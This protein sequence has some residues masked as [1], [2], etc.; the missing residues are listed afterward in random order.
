MENKKEKEGELDLGR[1]AELWK[2]VKDERWEDVKRQLDKQP[3]AITAPIT[4]FYETILHIL[5]NWKDALWLVKEIIKDIEEEGGPSVVE[6]TDYRG[7]TPLS[8]AASVGNAE[9]AEMIAQK[10]PDLLKKFNF[11]KESPF[12]LAAKARHEETFKRMLN[13]GQAKLKE[14]DIDRLFSGFIGASI[15][16]NLLAANLYGLTVSLLNS[17]PKLGRDDFKHRGNILKIL[18]EKPLAFESGCN[19]GLWERFIYKVV[20]VPSGVRYVY[21]TKIK[22]DQAR[23]VVHLVCSGVIWTFEDA[24]IALKQPVLRAATLGI[25]EIVEEILTVYPAATMFHNPKNYNI[26]QLAVLNRRHKVFNLYLKR[27]LSQKWVPTFP[28]LDRENNILHL[29]GR[30]V[31]S[32]HING[33]A[34]KMQL[35]MQ[36]FKAVESVVHPLLKEQRNSENKTPREVFEDEHKKLIEDGEKWMR[37]TASSCMVVDALIVAM[38]FAAI[39]AV[40]GNVEK[41]IPNFRNETVFKVFVVAD[42]AALFSS[43]FSLLLF[44]RILTSRYAENDFL[45]ALPNRLLLG[46]ITLILSI[47]AMLVASSSA[48]IML[49]DAVPGPKLVIKKSTL[50]PVTVLAAL[51]VIFFIW[52]QSYL[53]IDVLRATYR[54][55]ISFKQE[56]DD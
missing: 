44:V 42:T 6:K 54:P 47:A 52:S 45:S 11:R 3:D 41:G 21:E 26:F 56:N 19:F 46:I 37:D 27:C 4:E 15:V 48:L 39:I 28:I 38:V 2:A 8:V 36:W 14:Q 5:V 1:Y 20:L 29:A 25:A 17:Y 22:S 12:H 31:P 10:K 53:L 32:R 55:P 16:E 9:A 13:V 24:K 49:M 30:C 18:A 43:S 33:A 50:I 23:Q 35:E 40:P 34:L 51:P 7:N